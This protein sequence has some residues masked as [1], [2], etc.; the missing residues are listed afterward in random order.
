MAKLAFVFALMAFLLSSSNCLLKSRLLDCLNNALCGLTSA[1][2]AVFFI[3]QF[4]CGSRITINSLFEIMALCALFLMAFE[5]GAFV[6]CKRRSY[7]L[8]VP[9]TFIATV[10]LLLGLFVFEKCE[11]P[12]FTESV[13][14][15]AVGIASLL[16]FGA[17]FLVMLLR[18]VRKSPQLGN[19]NRLLAV[20]L[21]V[22]VTFTALGMFL[23][24]S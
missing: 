10:L 14:V 15:F 6:L 11:L 18:F 9:V 20:T 13:Y 2:L 16:L 5:L 8:I 21:I 1:V 7:S 12:P 17:G 4:T 3:L 24:R 19:M 23:V 22:G